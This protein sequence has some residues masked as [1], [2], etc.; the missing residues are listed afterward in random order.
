[1]KYDYMVKSGDGAHSHQPPQAALD[2]VV[3][4][5]AA[6]GVALHFVAP[7]DGI[8]E[9]V[10]TTLDPNPTPECAGDSVSTMR[11]LRVANF[12]N[13]QPAYHYLVFAHRVI[14][15]DTG[16]ASSCPTDPFCLRKPRPDATGL[17]DLPGDDAIVAFGAGFDALI[18]PEPFVVATTTMHELGHNFGLK[19]GGPDACVIDKPNYISVM[20]PQSY[21]LNGIPVA[22]APGSTDLRVCAVEADCQPP[23]V[24]AGTCASANACHCTT[25]QAATL[26]FDY[27]YRVDYSALDLPPL[28][29]LS[30]S[31]GVGGLD[32]VVGVSGPR[33]RRRHR[34]LLRRLVNNRSDPA[35]ARRSTGTA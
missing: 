13:L 5:F 20:S 1:V 32:E 29:E 9:T 14:T 3:Q 4:A 16:H 25:G 28:N 30:I 19:H 7:A 23:T 26:G 15:P 11:D 31:P 6:H 22:D 8:A 34:V 27:C 33:E 24:T 10:V 12:G 18:P 35:T 17:A 21:Q 2:Q